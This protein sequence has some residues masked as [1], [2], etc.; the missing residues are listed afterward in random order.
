MRAILRLWRSS[1]VSASKLAFDRIKSAIQ[2]ELDSG[3]L[4][5]HHLELVS[6]SLVQ[7]N[8]EGQQQPSGLRMQRL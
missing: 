2:T 5:G 6:A 7:L 1:S 4:K 3:K 8:E